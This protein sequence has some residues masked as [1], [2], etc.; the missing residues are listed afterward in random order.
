M[1]PAEAAARLEAV[2]TAENAALERLDAVTATSFLEEKLAAAQA[3]SA[4]GVSHATAERLRALA[5][6]NRRLLERA[7]KVQGRIIAMVAR[8]AQQS[9]PVSR[10]GAKG[11]AIRNAGAIAL[12]RQ[13]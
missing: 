6:E 4:E 3:L 11:G 9:P 1:S 8:A 13:A 7:I 2:L 5:A 10:Y 12:I